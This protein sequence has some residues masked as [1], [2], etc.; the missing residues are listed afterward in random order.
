MAAMKYIWFWFR[1]WVIVYVC[2][3]W[4]AVTLTSLTTEAAPLTTT[5][6]YSIV[7]ETTGSLDLYRCRFFKNTTSEQTKLPMASAHA[8]HCAP[9]RTPFASERLR[10][11]RYCALLDVNLINHDPWHAVGLWGVLLCPKVTL[12]LKTVVSK[13]CLQFI[14]L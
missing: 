11:K 14:D 2:T 6:C 12:N 5:L 3:H 1:L 13:S 10:C 8:Q 9:S 7:L 4:S